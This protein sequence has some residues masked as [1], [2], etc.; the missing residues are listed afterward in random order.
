MKQIWHLTEWRCLAI[1]LA[2]GPVLP[3]GRCLK[4]EF[5]QE[6]GFDEPLAMSS[7]WFLPL[8]CQG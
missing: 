4:E 1:S 8:P 5:A 6:S 3:R 7:S 2:V